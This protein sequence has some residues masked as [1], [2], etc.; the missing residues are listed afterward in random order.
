MFVNLPDG[1]IDRIQKCRVINGR[2]GI[3]CWA[4]RSALGS[5]FGLF[6]R[7]SRGFD[8]DD[9]L[10]DEVVQDRVDKVDRAKT[11]GSKFDENSLVSSRL[12]NF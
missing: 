8:R 11:F 1:G 4:F 7:L 12:Q 3:V 5:V 10:R 6:L 9:G 2:N